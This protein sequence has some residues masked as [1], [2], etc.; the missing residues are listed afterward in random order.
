MTDHEKPM[1][2]IS[3]ATE[4][5]S[6]GAAATLIAVRAAVSIIQ[7]VP[8]E[9]KERILFDIM[10][11]S[12]NSGALCMRDSVV[13]M[14]DELMLSTEQTFAKFSANGHVPPAV[15][16]HEKDILMESLRT[17]KS[18]FGREGFGL[19]GHYTIEE[20]RAQEATESSGEDTPVH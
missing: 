18:I 1:F 6:K 10:N 7:L 3:D 16:A 20:C 8:Q 14:F 11:E 5:T 9:Q 13:A 15:F 4:L 19:H 2:S 12:H 17:L